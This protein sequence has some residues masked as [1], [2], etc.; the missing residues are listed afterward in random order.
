MSPYILRFFSN[1]RSVRNMSKNGKLK[2]KYNYINKSLR[3]GDGIFRH[4]DLLTYIRHKKFK[5]VKRYMVI[6]GES[7]Y[8]MRRQV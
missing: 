4:S 5:I 7:T 3:E 1:Y 2:N 6:R 8:D